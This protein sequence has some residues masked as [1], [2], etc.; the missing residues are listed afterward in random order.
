MKYKSL[1]KKKTLFLRVDKR[2]LF[3]NTK[4]VSLMIPYQSSALSNQ[5]KL[6]KNLIGSIIL[7][8]VPCSH[9]VF[10]HTV[11]ICIPWNE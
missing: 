5:N 1:P 3:K 11:I 6:F 9:M 7:K 10:A 2:I 4:A 8:S